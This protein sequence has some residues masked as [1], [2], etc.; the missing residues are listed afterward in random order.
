VSRRARPGRGPRPVLAVLGLVAVLGAACGGAAGLASTP[1]A[2]EAY[3]ANFA[4]TALP[5]T[6]VTPVDLGTKTAGGRISIGSLPSALAA[7]PDGAR[8]VVAAQGADVAV[9]LDTADNSVLARLATGVEPDAVAVTPDGTTALVAN[10]GSNSL[11]PIDLRTLRAG[12]PI[13]VGDQP[14]AVAVTP[15]GSTAVVAD[16][17]ADAVTLVDLRTMTAGPRIPVG[18]EPDAATALVADLGDGTLTP[19][20]LATATAGRPVPVG[21]GPRAVVIAS[22]S[23]SPATAWVAVGTTLVPLTLAGIT[24]GGPGT[25]VAVGHVVEDVAL[26]RGDTEAWAAGL[27]GTLTPVDLTSGRTGRAVHVGGR[28]S[29]VA[30]ASAPS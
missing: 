25:P 10:L 4:F 13:A 8:L 30:V 16:L 18:S 27:D 15:D 2:A 11:T 29:A 7:T 1:G 12:A 24:L 3:V 5:G 19:V 22:A 14:D 17:A 6:T 9:V 21:A 28:P 23:G 20:D 26:A